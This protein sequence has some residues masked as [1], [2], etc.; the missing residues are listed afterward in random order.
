MK[1]SSNGSSRQEISWLLRE[2]YNNIQT[3]EF[4]KDVDRV[5]KGEHID[6]VIGFVDFLGCRIDL[7]QNP[8]IP[9]S[10]TEF[11]VEQVIAD[12]KSSR[13]KNIR[14]L[15]VFSGSG[16]IGIAILKH[17]P[18][19]TV[20]FAE[21]EKRFTKQIKINT[22]LNDINPQRYRIIQSDVFS[23]ISGMYN[24]IVANPPYVPERNKS[25]VQQSVLE[26]DPYDAVF[27]GEDGVNYIRQFLGQAKQ[28]LKKNGTIYMEF[29][30]SQ[31]KEVE[32]LARQSGY[33]NWQTFRDQYGKWRYGK[34]LY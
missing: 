27:G 11:W 20:D 29:D 7:S 22:D 8:F 1:I 19:A 33:R 34:L 24:L 31:Q 32:R 28:F 23:N 2:K 18:N 3:E 10:E 21:K 26:N 14:V 30:E 12:I 17:I 9:R 6:Y 25:Q 15:D 16:C 5:A 13:K 4:F